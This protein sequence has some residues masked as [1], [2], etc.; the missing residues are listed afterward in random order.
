M[1]NNKTNKRARLENIN[2]L[3][4][5][6]YFITVCTAQRRFLLSD[7]AVVENM[8]SF[9]KECSL[10]HDFIVWAY[11]FM[12]DH[13]HL[14]V[15]GFSEGSRLDKFVSLFKQKSGF[16]YKQK[17]GARLWQP[18][19]YDHVLRQN[20]GFSEIVLY[21]FSNPSR[22]GLVESCKDYPFSGSFEF[23]L[24]DWI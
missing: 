2:Y 11:C 16:W 15:E 20:E 13:L 1:K 9:L 22:A 21:I 14:L 8:I 12:P 17:F 5:Q 23:D 4:R 10:A 7:K 19:Y 24:N 18:S 3:G 6:R